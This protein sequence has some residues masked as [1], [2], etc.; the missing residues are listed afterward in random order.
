MQRPKKL[1]VR[2]K[3]GVNKAPGGHGVLNLPNG[4]IFVRLGTKR[5]KY[6]PSQ[7]EIADNGPLGSQSST[8]ASTPTA[9][10]ASLRR[11]PRKRKNTEEPSLQ[12]S[13]LAAVTKV[14]AKEPAKET[15]G[16]APA[17]EPKGKAPAK[18]P[19]GK[20]P[21]KQPKG[22]AP[23]KPPLPVDK[24]PKTLGSRTRTTLNKGGINLG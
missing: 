12:R 24:N 22:K 11:S 4:E 21:A 10:I 9:A 7:D 2:R 19:K 3:L 17:K 20:A 1:Q 23:A 13:E 18:E 6:Y 8:P 5:G 15:K 14:P 16:K